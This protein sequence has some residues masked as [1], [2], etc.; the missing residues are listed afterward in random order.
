M[1]VIANHPVLSFV[2]WL[3]GSLLLIGL[4]H[5]LAHMRV[6]RRRN[7]LRER[8]SKARLDLERALHDYPP[9]DPPH[10]VE[11]RRLPKEKAAENFDYFMR[12][13]MQR[14]AQF[15]N[16]LQQ[17]FAVTVTLDE[18]GVRA[19]GRWGN[20]YAGWLLARAAEGHPES[21]DAHYHTYYAYDP[22][23]TGENAGMNV[24]FD[25]GI[26][27]GEAI[28]ASCPKVHWDFDPISAILPKTA[29]MLK[30]TPGLGFQR[31]MLTGFDNPAHQ[32][33][34]LENVF[35]FALHMM[36]LMTTVEG[37]EKFHDQPR[38]FRPLDLEQLVRIFIDTLQNYPEGDPHKLR[39]QMGPQEF[40]RFVDA[41]SEEEDDGTDE[42]QP[43]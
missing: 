20:D 41:E 10:K 19:L 43:H 17:H 40:L 1:D 21:S 29:R 25:M 3:V 36:Q 12:V 37:I 13:R 14:V 7:C 28:I 30:R 24:V 15:R 31:P 16:W 33:I 6:R 32:S 8:L 11:E 5:S 9:Y 23:W 4:F 38:G 27:L 34:P 42:E 22:P 35:Y 18:E 26:T 2:G 39:E